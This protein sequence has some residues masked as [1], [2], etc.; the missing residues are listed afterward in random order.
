MKTKIAKFLIGLTLCTTMVCGCS[1][2]DS[3]SSKRRHS[4][5]GGDYSS[6][7]SSHS[8]QGSG[9]EAGGEIEAYEGNKDREIGVIP[10]TPV[11]SYSEETLEKIGAFVALIH[12]TAYPEM[13]NAFADC[14]LSFKLGDELASA[15]CDLIINYSESEDSIGESDDYCEALVEYCYDALEI[16]NST[17]FSY[18]GTFFTTLNNIYH[19]ICTRDGYYDTSS[20]TLANYYGP[21]FGYQYFTYLEYLDIKKNLSEFNNSTLSEIISQYDAV[22]GSFNFTD[23]QIAHFNEVKAEREAEA[24]DIIAVPQVIVDFVSEHAEESKEMLMNKFKLAVDAFAELAPILQDFASF[25]IGGSKKSNPFYLSNHL[26]VSTPY[27]SGI[28]FS[29]QL[30]EEPEP[31]EEPEFDLDEFYS[32]LFKRRELIFGVAKAI[33]VDSDLGDLLVAGANELL[34]P[35]LKNSY[36]RTEQNERILDG[37]TENVADLTGK[38]IS[39]FASFLLNVANQI[40]NKDL[41]DVCEY[42][43]RMFK[44]IEDEEYE[45]DIIAFVDKYL[46]NLTDVIAALSSEEKALITELTSVFG[47]DIFEEIYKFTRIFNEKDISTEEGVDAFL[48]ELEELY[49]EIGEK[50]YNAV[51]LSYDEEESGSGYDDDYQS[52]NNG[53]SFYISMDSDIRV[54]MTQQDIARKIYLSCYSR[55][56][57][58]FGFQQDEVYMYGNLA[59]WNDYVQS[60]GEQYRLMSS[61]E[62]ESEYG[63]AIYQRSLLAISELEFTPLDVSKVGYSQLKFSFKM[64]GSTFSFSRSILVGPAEDLPKIDKLTVNSSNL[65]YRFDTGSYLGPDIYELGDTINFYDDFNNKSVEINASRL[66]WNMYVAPVTSEYTDFDYSAYVYYV[67]NPSELADAK[68]GTY[69]TVGYYIVGSDNFYSE[70]ESYVYYKYNGLAFAERVTLPFN[71]NLV[72]G[73]AANQ[74]YTA[75]YQG[76]EFNYVIFNEDAIVMHTYGFGLREEITG[77]ITEPTTKTASIENYVR[78]EA[79][80]NGEFYYVQIWNYSVG[81]VTLTDFVYTNNVISF[82]YDGK[83][84]VFDV[85]RLADY[86]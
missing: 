27:T 34:I 70:P 14:M 73:K 74:K 24:A 55:Y 3:S 40:E 19:D 83:T 82:K 6:G 33:L 62:K 76:K 77:E 69:E 16:V 21:S 49:E 44:E 17:D 48:E 79:T 81:N 46:D 5:S 60:Y 54:G 86:L 61:E 58:E 67:V 53:V 26:S 31:E 57:N 78:Y 23:E 2:L 59:D 38:H 35:L 84:F 80:I 71:E 4:S 66:G 15:V 41:V 75:T 51:G 47:F 37:L 20:W 8:G 50:V 42:I 39:A 10:N 18:I 52:D 85:T 65:K 28:T 7:Q 12:G 22:Y 63:Q 72:N 30:D 45:F 32:E 25:S 13:V 68:T 56:T 11:N 64:K 29:D 36:P 1:D 9:G 43:F